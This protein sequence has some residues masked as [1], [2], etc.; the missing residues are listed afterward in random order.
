MLNAQ[1][2]MSKK[3]RDSMGRRFMLRD[4]LTK[5]MAGLL[6]MTRHTDTGKADAF[7]SKKKASPFERR[8]IPLQ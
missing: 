4:G 5:S 7:V 1:V 2:I 3:M 8:G 6:S